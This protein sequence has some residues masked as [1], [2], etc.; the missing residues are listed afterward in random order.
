MDINELEKFS[1]SDAVSFHDQLNPKLWGEDDQMKPEIREQL[2]TIAN[3]FIEELGIPDLDVEDITLSGSN[4]AF[5]YTPHSDIDLHVLVDFN[6]LPQ[7]EVYAELFN[8]KK[9]LYNEK[10]DITIKKIPVELYVQDSNQEHTSA[11]IYSVMNDE[12]LT[13][14]KKVKANINRSDVRAKYEKLGELIE[15]ALKSNDRDKILNVIDIVKR[16]RKAGLSKGGE[17]SPENLAFKAVRK[18]GLFQDLWDLKSDLKSDE[19]SIEERMLRE[20]Q[21]Q[22]ANEFNDYL[23]KDKTG[24]DMRYK[25]MMAEKWSEKYKKSINCKDPKGFSQRAHCDSRKL[26]KESRKGLRELVHEELVNEIDF[27]DPKLTKDIL[28]APIS[29]GFEAETVWTGISGESDYGPE[30]DS[31]DDVMDWIRENLG[32]RYVDEINEA[33]SMWIW[34]Y[35]THD[36]E[37]ELID[38]AFRERQEDEDV[39]NRYVEE[40]VDD[41]DVEDFKD[42]YITKLKKRIKQPDLFDYTKRQVNLAKDELEELEDWDDE[43]WARMYVDENEK[44]EF[45]DWLREEL[46]QDDEI[47]DEAYELAHSRNDMNDWIRD[48]YRGFWSSAVS[49]ITGQYMPEPGDGYYDDYEEA[50]LEDVEQSLHAWAEVDSYTDDIRTGGYHQNAGDTSQNYWRIE[51]DSS[52]EGSGA[53]AEIISPV[54]D[55]IGDM[56]KE[57]KSL[58]EYMEENDVETNKSTG[59]H[60]TM[61][62]NG[63]EG[64]DTNELK[65]VALMGDPY[66]L[67]QFDREFN[68]YTKSQQKNVIDY[69]K[70]LE[71]PGAKMKDFKA[72]EKELERG[73]DWSKFNA[74]NFKGTDVTNDK[75]NQL[76]EFRAAG[77][78][79]LGMLDTIQK[80]AERYGLT[81]LAG[82][83]DEA[84]KKD[85]IKAVAKLVLQNTG[86]YE[87]EYAYGQEVVPMD[88]QFAVRKIIPQSGYSAIIDQ[89]SKVYDAK[90]DDGKK[91]RAAK[92]AI[93]QMVFAVLNNKMPGKLGAKDVKELRDF[94]KF[95][96]IDLQQSVY[97]IQDYIMVNKP[98]LKNPDEKFENVPKAMT[99]LFAKKGFESKDYNDLETV[100]YDA[101]NDF[102]IM[103]FSVIRTILDGGKVENL[104]DM[105]RVIRGRMKWLEVISAMGSY[106]HQK[107][108]MKKIKA[109]ETDGETPEEIKQREDRIRRE[110]DMNKR[111]IMDFR[112]R[113]NLG[114]GFPYDGKYYERNNVPGYEALK[115]TGW[116]HVLALGNEKVKNAFADAGIMFQKTGSVQ[117]NKMRVEDYISEYESLLES[118]LDENLRAWFGKGKKGGAGGGGWDRYNTKGERIGKCGDSK[119]GEGKPKCLSKSRAASLR[120]KG[121]KAA[122]AAA[123]KKKRREDPN[124]NRRGKAKMVSNTTKEATDL[125]SIPEGKGI[126]M[127]QCP[128]CRGPIV[129]IDEAK[130]KKDAC[131]HK[132]RSRYRVWPSAYSSG[133]LVQCRKMG[134]DR[135]GNSSKKKKK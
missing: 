82:H 8:A 3:D 122:I 4:A 21:K 56:M 77:G 110:M 103:P 73:I 111:I 68:S 33:Y 78:D 1:L 132:V 121:G 75:D 74:I 62:W 16:Y 55:T 42:E 31:W 25:E 117:E 61:S 30:S 93:Q 83:D 69:A 7:S 112:A 114:S 91:E 134:A 24:K 18:H 49:D 98:R 5:T 107:E 135:W 106:L 67:K 94:V 96:D 85:Y 38:D 71:E 46:Y 108:N 127:T 44:E 80:T 133:A 92:M 34:E 124:K 32:D 47:R 40:R 130:G 70:R 58:F 119:P 36:I 129:H 2:L 118:S 105:Y 41:D 97:D 66:V 14:P 37:S 20:R 50:G 72:L 22:M 23:V 89:L 87:P 95:A 6:K 63:D 88:L 125:K 115:D 60:I 86:E 57:M 101:Y 100:K 51:S 76:I 28:N 9:N 102:V 128:H 13:I 65:M 17:F 52:I 126:P 11:G 84:F 43:A 90:D 81:M 131:Y 79:Y 116:V 26:K 123:V 109:G 29:C 48:Q 113:F 45:E 120:A 99:K 104:Q 39:I 35:V 10:H 19:L 54:Y 15:L 12:W 53:K 59:L 64:V 27:N